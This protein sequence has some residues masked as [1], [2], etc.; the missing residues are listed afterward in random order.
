[1]QL[2]C[3]NANYELGILLIGFIRAIR[4]KL[5]DVGDFHTLVWKGSLR[6]R[7]F[8]EPISGYQVSNGRAKKYTPKSYHD[9][10]PWL[11]KVQ[12]YTRLKPP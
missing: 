7:K 2:W 8:R 9:I 10:P 12:S 3:P 5:C 11:V 1:M 4:A 6:L